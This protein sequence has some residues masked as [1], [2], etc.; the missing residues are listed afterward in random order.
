MEPEKFDDIEFDQAWW[1][2]YVDPQGVISE[3]E[4]EDM[5]TAEKQ[6]L[7]LELKFMDKNGKL[8]TR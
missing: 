6:N 8:L 2:Q 4:F 3:E 7:L 1:D 5:D